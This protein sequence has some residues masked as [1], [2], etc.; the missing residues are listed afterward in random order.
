MYP[1]YGGQYA[2]APQPSSGL[3][4]TS[5]VC[6]IAGVLLFWLFVPLL[7]SIAAI[8]TGHLAIRQI[9]MTPGLGGRGMAIAGL[10][11]GYVMVAFG[12]L[13][14]AITLFSILFVGAFTLPFIFAS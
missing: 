1:A 3:A 9:R 2:P 6:G 12:V 11:M 8:I 13:S 14:I 7:G 5:L 10:V 4:V